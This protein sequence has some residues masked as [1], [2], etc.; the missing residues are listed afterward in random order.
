ML[1]KGVQGGLNKDA[2][3]KFVEQVLSPV[4]QDTRNRRRF[5]DR[6]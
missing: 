5:V 6:L 4:L 2:I 1:R 3:V